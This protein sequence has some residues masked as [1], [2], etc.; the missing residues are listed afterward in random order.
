M[1]II[2]EKISR[3]TN[4]KFPRSKKI[5]M[6]NKQHKMKASKDKA[7]RRQLATM[8]SRREIRASKRNRFQ[9]LKA[10][11]PCMA[12]MWC[13]V[14]FSYNTDRQYVLCDAWCVDNDIMI[15]AFE[16]NHPNNGIVASINDFKILE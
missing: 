12:V 10:Q 8:A 3:S 14:T 5:K 16:E 7:P 15:R 4:Q 9:E 11:L 2:F 13:K 1:G 6:I